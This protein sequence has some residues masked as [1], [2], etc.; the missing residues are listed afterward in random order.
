MKR[1]NSDDNYNSNVGNSNEF[2]TP[3]SPADIATEG[4]GDL[5]DKS[6]MLSPLMRTVIQLQ[7]FGAHKDM[8]TKQW[9]LYN[10]DTG[11]WQ[12]VEEE[13]V[14]YLASKLLNFEANV[15]RGKARPIAPKDLDT[16]R[17]QMVLDHPLGDFWKVRS[18]NYHE[19]L[20]FDNCV[21]DLDNRTTIKYYKELYLESKIE[22]VFDE[23]AGRDCPNWLKLISHLANNDEYVMKVLEAH[24][25]LA[26]V[27]KGR[28]ERCILSLYSEMGASGKGTYI[29]ALNGLV[30][31]DRSSTM[32]IA[33]L[34]DDTLLSGLQGKTLVSFPEEREV[35]RSSS[36]SFARILKLASLDDI[37]GRQVYSAS[38][39]KFKPEAIMVFASNV[40]VFPSDG[41]GSR[42]VLILKTYSTPEEDRDRD[43][44]LK[45]MQEYPMITNRLLERFDWNPSKAMALIEEAS[46]Y[47]TF[48]Q[49]AKENADETSTVAAYIKEML[50]PVCPI[51]KNRAL[52]VQEFKNDGN[53]M[54]SEVPATSLQ[55][56]Y[57]GYKLYLM[58]NNPGARP[59]KR[60]RFERE[61][62]QYCRINFQEHELYVHEGPLPGLIG[63]KIRI[64]GLIQNSEEWTGE[65]QIYRA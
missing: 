11:L 25:F 15:P 47:K 29:N 65:F 22:R 18:N 43:L 7:E 51:K 26:L 13:Y 35:L 5:H 31:N 52:T 32:E 54:G 57:E 3:Y 9:R 49:Y 38:R 20:P 34:S 63:K 28:L 46:K 16:F 59:L 39:F 44:G 48:V 53:Y 1:I 24:A 12:K 50:V 27:G 42:R 23:Q 21:L 8:E 58:G 45:I 37:V 62:F 60:S 17:F 41:A 61:L 30:G 55:S 33:R 36:N 6:T 40:H 14:I 19:Y 2:L 4:E 10:D 64:L 56:L